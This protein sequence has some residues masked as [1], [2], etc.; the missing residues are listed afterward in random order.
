M[1]PPPDRCSDSVTLRTSAAN[2]N[3]LIRNQTVL[4]PT[5][6]TPC[7]FVMSCM[8]FRQPPCR[9]LPRCT[10]QYHGVG[11]QFGCRNRVDLREHMCLIDTCGDV[12][13]F[14]SI[15]RIRLVVSLCAWHFRVGFL[16]SCWPVGVSAG[17]G[18][19]EARTLSTRIRSAHLGFTVVDRSRVWNA[20]SLR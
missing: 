4:I 20:K 17:C 14:R 13:L 8:A 7:R 5:G 3:Q 2:D 11:L 18:S 15:Q 19:K 16:T 12:A 6:T 9:H 10:N 1:P